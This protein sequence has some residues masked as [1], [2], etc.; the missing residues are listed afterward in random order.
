MKLIRITLGVIL[1]IVA[2]NAFGGGYYGMAGAKDIPLYWLH[3]SPF[4][5][6]FIPSLFL[7]IVLGGSCL[8]SSIVVFRNRKSAKT[9]SVFTGILMLVWITIQVLMIGFVSM[10][11][12]VIFIT[13]IIV[14]GLALSL[15]AQPDN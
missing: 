13:G 1:A 11:Q 10:L 3:G 9:A 15:K 7:F 2:V 12:P 8:Y 5:S 14:L 4:K 6:Y